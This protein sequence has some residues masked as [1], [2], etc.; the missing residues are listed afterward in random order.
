MRKTSEINEEEFKL[1]YKDWLESKNV[2]D[3]ITAKQVRI[4]Q[5]N[6]LLSR[7]ELARHLGTDEVA[8]P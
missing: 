8:R 7:P 2:F 4:Y 3:L 6:E 5:K 1:L